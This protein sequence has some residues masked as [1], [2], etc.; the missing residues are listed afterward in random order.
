MTQKY[1]ISLMKNV[2]TNMAANKKKQAN[3]T[4]T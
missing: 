1:F 2:T 3:V 4:P